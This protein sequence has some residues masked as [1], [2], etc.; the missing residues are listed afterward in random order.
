M[1]TIG[2]TLV[3]LS[4]GGVCPSKARTRRLQFVWLGLMVLAAHL[5]DIAEWVLTLRSRAQFSP[6]FVTHSIFST[7]TL[8]VI[9]WMILALW[10]RVRSPWPYLCIAVAV[11][12]HLLLDYLPARIFLIEL[13]GRTAGLEG[14]GLRESIIAEV[15]LYGLFLVI[16]MLWQAVRTPGCPRP[17]RHLAMAFGGVCLLAA[18]SRTA[19]LWA[20]VYAL[21]T[22]HSLLLLRRE[23][24]PAQLWSLV[25]LIPLVILV[26]IELW[27]VF[28]FREALKLQKAGDFEGAARLH[29]QTLAIPSRSSKV[30]TYI[31]LSFCEGAKENWAANEHD[32][33]TAVRLAEDPAW[34]ELSLAEFYLSG[35]VIGTSYYRPL[36]AQRLA[37]KVAA[38]PNSPAAKNWAANILKHCQKASILR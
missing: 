20:P 10:A 8:V 11:F 24:K 12:S 2:H 38:G 21:A 4:L 19:A 22:A 17:A 29:R 15:W 36:E 32:L 33:L 30:S 28:L 31:Y 23:I 27:S 13:Y 37:E 26:G 5:V 7:T 9:L 14:I 3:G 16:V 1:A 35:R 34:P 25:P 18:L 6:H